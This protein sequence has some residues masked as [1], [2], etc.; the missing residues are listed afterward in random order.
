M[1][2]CDTE[3]KSVFVAVCIVAADWITD[4]HSA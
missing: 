4:M 2:D 3:D 1:K